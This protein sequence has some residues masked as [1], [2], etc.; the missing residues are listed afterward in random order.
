M[1]PGVKQNGLHA[2]DN[3]LL[4]EIILGD[5][6]EASSFAS[7]GASL[8]AHR[9]L[10]AGSWH[11]HYCCRWAAGKSLEVAKTKK[12][13]SCNNFRTWTK[14]ASAWQV[15]VCF[16]DAILSFSSI[17]IS[18]LSACSKRLPNRQDDAE[19]HSPAL[20]R[21][22]RRCSNSLPCQRHSSVPVTLPAKERWHPTS[23]EAWATD[24]SSRHTLSDQGACTETD[25]A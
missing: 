21:K 6:C 25:T 1:I 4:P 18:K 5:S 11:Q 10:R 20:P 22:L 13:L 12:F 9:T 8:P 17:F 24:I 19:P 7:S 15:G 3:E 16:K 14:K 2:A 23:Y